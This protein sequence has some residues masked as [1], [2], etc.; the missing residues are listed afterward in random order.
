[1]RLM[2]DIENNAIIELWNGDTLPLNLACRAARLRRGLTI[3]DVTRLA[4][5]EHPSYRNFETG[6]TKKMDTGIRALFAMGY[7]V[8]FIPKEL[9]K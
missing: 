1:M 8:A 6:E 2:F 9:D 7:S 4:E 3:A 5:L